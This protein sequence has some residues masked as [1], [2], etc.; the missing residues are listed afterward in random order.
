MYNI[1]LSIISAQSKF[2][3]CARGS[4]GSVLFKNNDQ[5]HVGI[6]LA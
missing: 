4:T 6:Q 3:Q 5:D 2:L 1:D